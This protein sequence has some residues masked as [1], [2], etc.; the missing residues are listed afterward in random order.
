ML[1]GTLL[2]FPCLCLPLF[3]EIAGGR[4]S[5]KKM[6]GFGGAKYELRVFTENILAL[7]FF[8]VMY[9]HILILMR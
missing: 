2:A 5:L 7:S 4:A 3:V 8:C 9:K 6:P 1:G